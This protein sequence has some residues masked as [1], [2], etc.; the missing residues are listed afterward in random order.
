MKRFVISVELK[1]ATSS[2]KYEYSGAQIAYVFHNLAY[3]LRIGRPMS[4]AWKRPYRTI[5]LREEVDSL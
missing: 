2:K 5:H 3:D 1:C 4:S